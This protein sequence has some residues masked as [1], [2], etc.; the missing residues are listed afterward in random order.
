MMNNTHPEKELQAMLQVN[1]SHRPCGVSHH[2]E[3]P[4]SSD[5]SSLSFSL[6]LCLI[7][8]ASMLKMISSA[9]FLA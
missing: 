4:P 3:W 7:T 1:V 8:L 5:Y 6:R 9:M 2:T